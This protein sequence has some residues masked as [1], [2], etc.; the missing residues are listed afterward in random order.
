MSV[1]LSL[2]PATVGPRFTRHDGSAAGADDDFIVLPDRSIGEIVSAGTN[3]T[4]RGY[5]KGSQAQLSNRIALAIVGGLVGGFLGFGLMTFGVSF[6]LEQFEMA[7]DPDLLELMALAAMAGAGLVSAVIGFFLPLAFRKPMVT[8]VGRDGIQRYIKA[9]FGGAANDILRF[10]E[11]DELRVSRTRN[12]YNGSYVGTSYDYQWSRGGARVFQIRGTYRDDRTDPIDPVNFAFAA[13]RAWTRFRL[14][15]VQQQ[16]EREGIVH[17]RAGSDWIGVGHGFIEIGWKG[18]VERLE[19]PALQSLSLNKG[20]LVIKRQGAK[21]GLFRSE[22][23]FQFP[24]S[25]MSDFRTFLVALEA[26]TGYRFS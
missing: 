3:R 26:C 2:V 22:G 5:Y 12:H 24:V 14:Q 19:K 13:E 21:V 23:V 4:L 11:A 10:A 1:D 15:Q 9:R 20:T 8:Y 16:I 6:V 25:A 7:L 17:F 18:A